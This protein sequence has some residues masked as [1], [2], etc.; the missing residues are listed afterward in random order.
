MKLT[1]KGESLWYL[2]IRYVLGLIMLSYGW[3]KILGLQF[4]L[5]AD[6]YEYQLKDIDGVTLVWAFLGFSTWFSILL[7]LA[8]FVPALLL[9]FR[10][11][12]LIGAILLFPALFAVCLVNNAYGFSPHMRIFTG[13]L[14]MMDLLLIS[15]YDQGIIKFLQGLLQKHLTNKSGELIINLMLVLLVLLLIAFNFK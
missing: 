15:A 8:E 4:M 1:G 6:V 3:I 5:P 11:T 2:I 9:L 14:L 12:K 13:I 7:G 10:K